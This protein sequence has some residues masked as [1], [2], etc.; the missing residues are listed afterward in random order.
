M[1]KILK[2]LDFLGSSKS[3]LIKSK[4]RNRSLKGGL[5]I[6]LLILISIFFIIFELYKWF[7]LEYTIT[8]FSY[9][10]D[11]RPSIQINHSSFMIAFCIG[12]EK[13]STLFDDEIEGLFNET[14]SLV[15]T[16]RLPYES[17][18]KLNIPISKCT[19]KSFPKSTINEFQIKL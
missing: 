3:F 10:Y 5:T 17:K 6:V 11:R 7:N 13:N 8:N 15:S 9:F 1:K 16:I 14:L 12:S 19:Q 2:K 4:I 18:T